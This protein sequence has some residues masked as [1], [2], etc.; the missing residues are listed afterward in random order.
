MSRLLAVLSFLTQLCAMPF[1]DA[2]STPVARG[3]S[4]WVGAVD[5]R[6]YRGGMTKRRS[7]EAQFVDRWR[8]AGPILE[9]QRVAELRALADQDGREIFDG[10]WAD[11]RWAASQGLLCDPAG[12]Y[13]PGDPGNPDMPQ[14]SLWE[15]A[16]EVLSVCRDQ[17][18]AACVIGG[19][20]VLRWGEPRM[21]RDVDLAVLSA[22]E[23]VDIIDQLLS[24]FPGR[25][26]QAGV[27][28]RSSHVL[29]MHASNGIAVDITFGTAPF[30][31][32][33]VQR[34]TPWGSTDTAVI[35]C[36]AEDLI[37]FKVFAGRARDWA[38]IE[39][40]VNRQSDA[41]DTDLIWQELMPLLA[42]KGDPDGATRLRR[43]LQ[44]TVRAREDL[45]PRPIG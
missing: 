3:L 31:R 10:L 17:G 12:S 33:A 35:T 40:I 41:L 4:T 34:A 8:V 19:V 30:Q 13:E 32:R 9:R 20:A 37:T 23:P 29:Q 39:G 24:R 42:A 6:P 36:R 15:A 28:A 14:H 5:H 45:N 25:T 27:L 7:P 21:T 26:E 1:P 11:L 38:D 18:W 2:S 16:S 43:L 44:Q 22:A